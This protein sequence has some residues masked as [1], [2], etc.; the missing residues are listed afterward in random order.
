MP[1]SAELAC[2]S[3]LPLTCYMKRGPYRFPTYN[4][5]RDLKSNYWPSGF[6]FIQIVVQ[7]LSHV[8]LFETLWRGACQ[9]SL[10]FTISQS[11]PKLTSIALVMPSNHLI[12][13]HYVLLL[14]S[15][16]PS[17]GVFSNELALHIWW[18]KY[19]YLRTVF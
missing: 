9:A 2:I 10:S 13:C 4:K 19:C 16:L 12:P 3:F 7:L 14:P 18:P 11:L 6:T 1:S 8:H 15:I 17:I 5:P